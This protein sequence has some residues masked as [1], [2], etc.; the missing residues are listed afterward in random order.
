MLR[1]FFALWIGLQG[2][3]G[4]AY[5]LDAP[6]TD[7]AQEARARALFGELRC[8]VCQNQSIADSDADLAKDLRQIVREKVQT[9]A[10]DAQIKSFVVDRYGEFVLLRPV[11]SAR[12]WI[13]WLAPLL[14]L[15]VGLGLAAPLFLRRSQRETPQD[16]AL[17]DEELAPPPAALTEDEQRQL[18]ALLHPS[19]ISPAAQAGAP[20]F[21][22]STNP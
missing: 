16:N 20:T 5:A 15:G 18:N 10:Q 1:L 6:L 14:A 13:L 19:R 9:G 17:Q 3:A 22:A 8:L 11:V 21:T 7:P 4:P 2:F 12:T